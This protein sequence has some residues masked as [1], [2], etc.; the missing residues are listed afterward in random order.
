MQKDDVIPDP[1]DRVKIYAV[2][3]DRAIFADPMFKDPANQDFTLRRGSLAAAEENLRAAY[4]PSL[5]W[6]KHEFPPQLFRNRLN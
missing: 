2:N 1:L 5:L 6:W 4:P 3:G